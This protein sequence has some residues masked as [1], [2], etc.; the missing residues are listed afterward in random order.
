IKKEVGGKT[1]QNRLQSIDYTYNVRG[2]LTNI[3]DVNN[4]GAD[5]FTFN[6]NYNNPTSG[7]A[8]YN[9]NISQTRWKTANTDSSTKTYIYTYDALN[10]ITRADDNTGKYD[11]YGI[12]YDKNGNLTSLRRDGHTNSSGTSF[13]VMDN[14]TYTYDSGNKLKKV[15]DSGNTTYGFKDGTNQTTEY[16]YDLNGNMKTDANK[17]I[18]GITY[19]HLNLPVSIIFSNGG[20]IGYIYDANGI[21]LRKEVEESSEDPYFIFYAGNFIYK[22]LE[23]ENTALQFFNT[24]EGYFNV[25]GNTSGKA[26]GNYVY[27]YKDHLGNVRLSYSDTNNNGSVNAAEIIE[28]SNYYPFGLKHKGYNNVVSPNGNATAQKYKFN[29]KEL[30]DELGLDWYD[31]GA[32]NYDASLGRW[33][34]LDPLA[35]Q[36]RR[37]SPYNYAFNNPIFFIDPDGMAP[38]DPENKNQGGDPDPITAWFK[39]AFSKLKTIFQSN[40]QATQ[41]EIDKNQKKDLSNA[42]KTTNEAINESTSITV[43]L[44]GGITE[45]ATG[46]NYGVQAELKATFKLLDKPTIDGDILF[47]QPGVPDKLSMS[48]N[49]PLIG[50]SLS[51]SKNSENDIKTNS[52]LRGA[53]FE[54]KAQTL[55]DSSGNLKSS[56]LSLGVGATQKQNYGL[57]TAKFQ[58]GTHLNVKFEKKEK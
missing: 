56:T 3:N 37:H 23:G 34:N 39:S 42:I 1:N 26:T 36:M 15:A 28:E 29:G 48:Y 24:P 57:F 18:T 51:A 10:R 9:G 4:I 33:M 5:L 43:K 21:K 47:K 44:K 31:F 12:A 20:H 49:T 46:E 52:T 30:N 32:R 38:Q 16:T 27:Q 58:A 35:E 22:A 53:F 11:L 17:G 55:H 54:S 14:L 13:G 45:N 8:L 40:G 25:T 50:A 19:N 2:W 41:S 6:I 7:T